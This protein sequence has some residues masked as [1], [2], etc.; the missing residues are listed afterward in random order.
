MK[1]VR[2]NIKEFEH[3]IILNPKETPPVIWE[4]GP[5][6]KSQH[7]SNAHNVNQYMG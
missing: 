2:F 6:N 3:Q 7:Y 4:C 1:T 5:S